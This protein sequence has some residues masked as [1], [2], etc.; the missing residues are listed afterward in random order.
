MARASTSL[1]HNEFET[2][3]D[4]ELRELMRQAKETLSRR[5]TERIDE[6][7]LL[8]REAGFEV[9]LT[10]LG[11]DGSRRKSRRSAATTDIDSRRDV[12]PKYRNPDR[13]AEMW[14]GRGR[15][16]RWLADKLA[17]GATVEDFLISPAATEAA[18][19]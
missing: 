13:P 4:S 10:K 2:M 3:S 5:I 11:E 12:A 9:T 8:A 14:S 1:E 7:R 18:S 16:P 6:F 17:K 15:K 19:A